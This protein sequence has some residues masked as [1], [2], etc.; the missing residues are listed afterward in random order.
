MSEIPALEPGHREEVL[1]LSRRH[2]KAFEALLE[3]GIEDGSIR[4]CDVR[5][6]GNA[7]MGSINWIPKWFHGKPA[8]ASEVLEEFPDVLTRGLANRQA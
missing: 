4:A 2:G 1:E 6:T 5:M 8:V 7:I 3:E